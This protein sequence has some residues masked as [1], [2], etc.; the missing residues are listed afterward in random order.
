MVGCEAPHQKCS[1]L[2]NTFKTYD[3]SFSSKVSIR[4][5]T[6]ICEAIL[7]AKNKGGQI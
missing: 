7:R 4:L 3:L 2:F 6:N 1:Y 5:P